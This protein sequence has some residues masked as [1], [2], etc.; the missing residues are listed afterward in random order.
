[1]RVVRVSVA[2]LRRAVGFLVSVTQEEGGFV[3]AGGFD[4]SF[5]FLP[6]FTQVFHGLAKAT[7]TL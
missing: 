1:L 4:Q 3:A 7:P 2:K 5:P 6:L